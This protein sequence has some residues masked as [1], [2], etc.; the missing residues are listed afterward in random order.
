MTRIPYTI[1]ATLALIRGA[2]LSLLGRKYGCWK[3]SIFPLGDRWRYTTCHIGLDLAEARR[4]YDRHGWIPLVFRTVGG[5][6]SR[7][8]LVEKTGDEI[9]LERVMCGAYVEYAERISR[10]MAEARR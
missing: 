9:E 3:W 10:E 1:L 5:L 7:E 8:F 2:I 6:P 4:M